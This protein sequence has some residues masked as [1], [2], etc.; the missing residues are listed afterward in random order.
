MGKRSN[1]ARRPQDNY[2]TPYEAVLPLIPHL[3]AAKSY[4]EPCCGDGRLVAHLARHGMSYSFMG[5]IN[6][7]LDARD[8]VAGSA[9]DQVITNPPWSRPILHELILH[10]S[11]QC[12]TWLLFD[13]DWMHTKQ[14]TQYM[15]H[16]HKIVSVGRVSWM[17]NGQTGK[18]NCCWYLFDQSRVAPCRF[19]GRAA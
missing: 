14:S 11:K 5:D 16:C 10:F 2:P 17:E 13:A 3:S 1:F 6:T 18:D 9:C 15:E 4:A 8:F 19:V 12:P 7:G